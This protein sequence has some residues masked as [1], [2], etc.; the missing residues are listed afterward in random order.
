MSWKQQWTR[1][2][3]LDN[4]DA[5]ENQLRSQLNLPKFPRRLKR[6]MNTPTTYKLTPTRALILLSLSAS[7]SALWTLWTMYKSSQLTEL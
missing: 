3:V 2:L 6:P 4:E 5:L 1:S 7:F